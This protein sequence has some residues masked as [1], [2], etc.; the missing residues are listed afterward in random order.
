MEDDVFLGMN[1]KLLHIEANQISV[2]DKGLFRGVSGLLS[3]HTPAYKFCCIRPNYLADEDC[4]PER[5]EFSSCADLL[6]VSA[7]QTMLWLIGLVALFGNILSVIYRLI[8]DRERL[9]LG[10]GIFVTNLAIADFIMGVYLIIIAIAD[11]AYRKRFINLLILLYC[12]F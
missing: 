6:R 12:T 1:A 8:Y 7:L 5:D 11:A 9:K 3:L 2:F 4:F 10:F